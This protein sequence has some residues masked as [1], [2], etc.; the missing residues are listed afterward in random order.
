MFTWCIVSDI[1]LVKGGVHLVDTVEHRVSIHLVNSIRQRL[2][3]EGVHLVDSIYL[4]MV[5]TWLKGS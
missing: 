2:V 4:K 1:G 3:K 5:F